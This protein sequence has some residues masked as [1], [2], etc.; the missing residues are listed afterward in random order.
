MFNIYL[1]KVIFSSENDNCLGRRKYTL[2]V[3]RA[4]ST[5]PQSISPNIV[6]LVGTNTVLKFYWKP[7][8]SSSPNF[9]TDT[10]DLL[11]VRLFFRP[12]LSPQSSTPTHDKAMPVVGMPPP[13][14]C[15]RR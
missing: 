1:I 9:I 7:D 5:A 11:Y 8:S 3:L 14:R 6:V 13:T 10:V 4:S 2:L 12:F 15:Y